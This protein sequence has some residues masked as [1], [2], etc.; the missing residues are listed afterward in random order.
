MDS[1]ARINLQKRIKNYSFASA[2]VI[3]ATGVANAQIWST[4]VNQTLTGTQS[5][6]ISFNGNTKF[7]IKH[8][9]ISSLFNYASIHKESANAGWIKNISNIKPKALVTSYLINSTKNFTAPNYYKFITGGY[10]NSGFRGNT[11]YIGVKFN[12]I[13]GAHY[14]WIK[15]NI[16]TNV[17]SATVVSYGYD[18]TPGQGIKAGSTTPLPIELNSFI[19]S[20]N[21]NSVELRWNTAT[22]V[23]NYGFAVERRAYRQAGKPGNGD[24]KEVGFVGGAGNSAV[25]KAYSY[26]DNTVS[27]GSY[28]YRLK[29]TDIDGSY[30]YSDEVTVEVLSLPAEF[31]LNQN[32]PNPFNPSTTIKYSIPEEVS[33]EMVTLKIFNMLGQEVAA[34]VNTNQQ[35]GN[36]EVKFDASELASGIYLY[37]L[38]AGN[39][40]K[41]MRMNLLK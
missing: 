18:A 13:D 11:K 34:L 35:A 9:I 20:V 26:T 10:Y 17:S 29:Q 7:T 21:G 39:F 6:S 24:W 15:L 38:T 12:L 28:I 31:T 25:A 40:T 14:G 23:N 3:A 1:S 27:A 8:N 19:S 33:N 4:D 41:T 2:A 30:T 32:Y 37:K 36:Y 22:E 16:P 5:L